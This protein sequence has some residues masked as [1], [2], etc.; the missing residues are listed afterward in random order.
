MQAEAAAGFK[1]DVAVAPG[2][3]AGALGA[4]QRL[5]NDLA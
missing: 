3:A 5:L 4:L 2:G 1:I